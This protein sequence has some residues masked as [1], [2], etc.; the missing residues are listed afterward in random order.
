[1]PIHLILFFIALSVIGGIALGIMLHDYL[2]EIIRY[3]P[4]GRP[5]IQ[6]NS[7]NNFNEDEI[8]LIA[9]RLKIVGNTEL[10]HAE[11]L[12]AIRKTL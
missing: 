12:A 5:S 8:R 7:Y 1:M 2:V 3:G 9:Q 10:G 4:D 11:L 6:D